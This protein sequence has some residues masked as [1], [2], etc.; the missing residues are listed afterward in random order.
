MFRIPHVKPEEN[1]AHCSCRLRR[2]HQRPT[3]GDS[4]R[5]NSARTLILPG[6]NSVPAGSGKYI[7]WC[8]APE[9][10]ERILPIIGVFVV[11]KFNNPQKAGKYCPEIWDTIFPQEFFPGRSLTPPPVLSNMVQTAACIHAEGF[12][13]I[14]ILR[15]SFA[16]GTFGKKNN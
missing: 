16:V 8:E 12:Y 14:I 11:V 2:R 1:R 7:D 6:K 10:F 13:W 3:R 4:V 9:I 15:K 5:E